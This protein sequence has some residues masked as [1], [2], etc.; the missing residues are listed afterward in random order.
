MKYGEKFTQKIKNSVTG[1]TYDS[2]ATYKYAEWRGWHTDKTGDG[3]WNGDTQILG[4]CQFSVAGCSTEK[5]AKAKIR[6]FVHGE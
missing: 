3:L 5:V 1:K 4:T 2:T 6:K